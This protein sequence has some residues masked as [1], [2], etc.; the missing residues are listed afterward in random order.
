MSELLDSRLSSQQVRLLEEHRRGCA[1]CQARWQAMQRVSSVFQTAE[2][3]MPP[4]D[5]VA[6]V[7]SRLDHASAVEEREPLFAGR[8]LAT[9]ATVAA[10]FLLML[11]GVG[12]FSE[13]FAGGGVVRQGL[14]VNVLNATLAAS[15][16]VTDWAT[17]T[18]N[19]F[20]TGYRVLRSVP[21][22]LLVVTSLWV[23]AGTL[24]LAFTL[25]NVI[26]A[27][28]PMREGQRLM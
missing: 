22:V 1:A 28:Q 23:V 5:F 2:M 12:F 14:S 27:Y 26:G 17:I 20:S 21:P 10:A 11:A 15:D 9:W 4:P 24:A 3:A 6:Q 19:G 7:M 18:N 8:G 13:G 25:A 16:I